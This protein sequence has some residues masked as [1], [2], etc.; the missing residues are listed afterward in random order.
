MWPD[1]FETE[2]AS[3]LQRS[4][5]H[6]KRNEDRCG[7]GNKQW[8][9]LPKQLQTEQLYLQ[10]FG[11]SSDFSYGPPFFSALSFLSPPPP[12]FRLAYTVKSG[13]L[14]QIFFQLN[15]VLFFLQLPPACPLFANCQNHNAHLK[16]ACSQFL[17]FRFDVTACGWGES[18]KRVGTV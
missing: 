18:G 5:Q 14:Y 17:R 16:R 12:L 9:R 15:F 8:E 2:K 3:L 4:D 6:Q 1:F 7:G 13:L 10:Y 11:K